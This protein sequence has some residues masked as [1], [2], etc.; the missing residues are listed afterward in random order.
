MSAHTSQILAD[1]VKFFNDR[2]LH[3]VAQGLA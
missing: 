1:L 3:E 2:D